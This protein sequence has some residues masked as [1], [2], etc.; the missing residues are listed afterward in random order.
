MT[1]GLQETGRCARCS[2]CGH[3]D[4]P[5]HD[6]V[7]FVGELHH[8]MRRSEGTS[9]S[10]NS[11][12]DSLTLKEGRF[13]DAPHE[14]APLQ[15]SGGP[16]WVFGANNSA[17]A[18]SAVQNSVPRCASRAG[19]GEPVNFM[20]DPALCKERALFVALA[21]KFADEESSAPGEGFSF[22]RHGSR[23]TTAFPSRHNSYDGG[24]ARKS[25]RVG[26]G[27]A[28]F[29]FEDYE[30]VMNFVEDMRTRFPERDVSRQMPRIF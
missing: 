7:D 19:A 8:P 2:S 9:D 24:S 11:Y 18:V 23:S 1:G 16:E 26:A 12:H 27:G 20:R 17:S 4:E 25:S 3:A 5:H 21:S 13:A 22:S 28:A 10:A 15:P 14:R 29:G 6:G 30:T